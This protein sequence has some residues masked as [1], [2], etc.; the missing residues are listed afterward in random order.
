[1]A[2][3][4]ISLYI[5]IP[6][7]NSKCNYCAF[8]SH[9][10]TESEKDSYV[11]DLIAEIKM[12]AQEYNQY[13][14]VCSI[15]IGGGTPSCMNNYAI[16]DILT[17]I[18][19]NFN[20]KNS[21]EITIEAN[22][23]AVTRAKI[24][25]YI[26]SGV[27]R[28]S[29]GLQCTNQKVLSSMGRTHTVEDFDNTIENIREQGI[30]NISA[31]IMIG[32]PGQTLKH[33]QESVDHLIELKI[34]HISCYMLQVEEGT[35]LK[36]LVDNNAAYLIT[37]DKV[38]AMYNYVLKELKDNGYE[39]YELSNFSKPGFASY[40]NQVYWNRTDYLGFGVS[41]HS[42]VSGVRFSNTDSI[43]EYH[44]CI[45]E[46]KKPPVASAQ[47]LTKQEKKE[48]A[49]MLSL[50]TAKGLDTKAYEAEFG[51]NLIAAK[52]D[53]LA[54]LIKNGFLILD[55]EGILKATDKGYLVL[56]RLIYEI[57]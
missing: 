20:V 34:P 37:E 32:Y 55:K 11:K 27:N 17:C 14:S 23:N 46:L 36:A 26:L 13:F 4:D 52:K 57:I 8:V 5:H 31:D 40:H 7:C 24:R 45:N 48:E 54:N 9:V 50:R 3:K 16:R 21:A 28:F 18:Y 10:G 2:K 12:R 39:R 43:S 35:K 30:S 22:P 47:E 15:Y 6:F 53:K 42:Y 25:E 19:K 44:R 38:I 51:E 29:V 56:N 33:V 41:A 1:M 49:I